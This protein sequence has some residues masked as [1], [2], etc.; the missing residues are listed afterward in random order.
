LTPRPVRSREFRAARQ[1]SASNASKL[2]PSR[3]T[4]S[5]NFFSVE[6]WQWRD[7]IGA[8]QPPLNARRTGFEVAEFLILDRKLMRKLIALARSR[9]GIDDVDAEDLVQETALEIARSPALI[10]S[11]ESYAF[12]V[13]HN[14]CARFLERRTRTSAV[15]VETADWVR[16]PAVDEKLDEKAIVRAGFARISVTC[17]TLLTSYYVEGASLKETAARS[18]HSSKQVW[19]RLSACL[20]KLKEAVGA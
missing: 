11:P 12:Q 9:F 8:V 15:F 17:R 19:K 18:G 5:A 3:C 13:F 6:R 2:T 16:T 20:K 14:R 7:Y 4:I 1:P 10:A